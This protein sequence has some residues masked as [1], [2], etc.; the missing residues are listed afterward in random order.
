[1]AQQTG[2]PPSA[3]LPE[4]KT[5]GIKFV[6]FQRVQWGESDLYSPLARLYARQT[7][8]GS[9]GRDCTLRVAGVEPSAPRTARSTGIHD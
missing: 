5:D 9:D 6:P 2:L 7:E 3:A 4:T 1:M 8:V